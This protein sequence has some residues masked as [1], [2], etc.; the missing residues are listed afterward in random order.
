MRAFARIAGVLSFFWLFEFFV[1]SFVESSLPLYKYGALIKKDSKAILGEKADLG[2]FESRNR[3][4]P[5]GSR[6]RKS[7]PVTSGIRASVE[8]QRSSR[9]S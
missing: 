7:S 2:A 5:H 9:S 8:A 3:L 4:R 1:P 6:D